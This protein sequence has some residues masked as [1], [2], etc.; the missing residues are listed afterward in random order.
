MEQTLTE[1]AVENKQEIHSSKKGKKKRRMR[2]IIIIVASLI[3][4]R[5]ALPY[6]VLHY[7][8]KTLANMDG[9]YGH[10]EDIDLAIYRGAY[11]IKDIYLNKKDSVTNRETEFFNTRLIDLSIH[12]N[13][14]LEGKIVGELELTDPTLRFTKDKVE[15]AELQKDTTDFRKLLDGFMPLKIN[16]FEIIN[17]IIQYVD[18]NSSPKVNIEMTNTHILAENLTTEKSETLLPSTVTASAN[19]Y[20]GTLEF[21]MK[22]DALADNPTFDMNAELK[23]TSLPKLNEFFKAY[24][25]FDVNKGTM[26]MYTEVAARDNKFVGYV[27][28]IIKDLDVVGKEDKND[29]TLHKVWEGFIGSIGVI[30]KNQ[31]HDQVATKVP[32]EGTLKNAS[33]NLWYA[34]MDVLR[35]AFIRALQPSLDNEINIG[36]VEQAETEEEKKGFI[37]KIFDK[38]TKQDDGDQ[39]KEGNEKTNK[40]SK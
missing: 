7:A 30:L 31:K 12:W 27:K 20:D 35:N 40:N 10:V 25:K 29:E 15:P 37:Q 4:I 8:N 17:G 9:Y 11:K 33:T 21:N 36:T 24:G 2:V 34:I 6:V 23:N 26:G 3:A 39:K 16:R 13:A 32:M 14:L 5:I 38:K 19:V 18:N 28:P 22:L 1:P